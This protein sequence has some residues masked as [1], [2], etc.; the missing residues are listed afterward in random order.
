MFPILF[1]LFVAFVAVDLFLAAAVIY[2]LRQYTLPG[3]NAAKV[4]IPTYIVLSLMFL[5]A[6]GF[7]LWQ[8]RNLNLPLNIVWPAIF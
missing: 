1:L 7:Y 2:H 8:M 4:V 3:W 6:A 5:A